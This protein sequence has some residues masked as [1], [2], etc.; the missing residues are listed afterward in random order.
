MKRDQQTF[1][2]RWVGLVLSLAAA[3]VGLALVLMARH[4]ASAVAAAESPSAAALRA[5][6]AFVN[7][8]PPTRP[9]AAPELWPTPP[10]PFA[11]PAPRVDPRRR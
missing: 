6:A 3:G 7:A 8:S 11:P 1:M 10:D 5:Q 4:P 2:R 9:L